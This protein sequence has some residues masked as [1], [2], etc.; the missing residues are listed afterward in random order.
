MKRPRII[1]F[2]EMVRLFSRY[3]V[4]LQQGTK[5]PFLAAP[6]GSKATIPRRDDMPV[7][8][9]EAARRRL[10]L[11]RDDGVKD[12]DFYDRKRKRR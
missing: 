2:R 9:V 4:K 11:S 12:E 5:H 10:G 7:F 8:Y 3:G 1:A 6:D